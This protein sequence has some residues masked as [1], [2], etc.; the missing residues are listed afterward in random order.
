MPD[1]SR[2]NGEP[3]VLPNR[4]LN[5]IEVGDLLEDDDQNPLI[6]TYDPNRKSLSGS[7]GRCV[8]E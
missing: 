7:V 3:N 8:D 4:I 1:H 5:T 2:F 6:H